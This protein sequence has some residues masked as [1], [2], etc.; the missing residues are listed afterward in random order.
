MAAAREFYGR[1]AR[2]YDYVSRWFPG[3]ATVR[4]RVAAALELSPGDRVVEFGCGTGANFP[5][6]RDA[7]GPD[8]E[9]VG[10]DFTGPSVRRARD[11]ARRRG[12]DNVSVVQADA[13]VPPVAAADGVVATFVMG[14]LDDPAG[15]V[16]DWCDRSSGTVVL[17]DAAPAG[18][19]YGPLVNPPFRAFV[20]VSTPPTTRLRYDR[21]LAAHL[22]ERVSAAHAALGDRASAAAAER[23]CLGLVR[24]TGGRVR[25]M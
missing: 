9:V 1:W 18:P 13:T 4:R 11:R 21:D 22:D 25:D 14:M 17:A 16:A 8:G 5:F 3:I 20:T 10:V 2:L 15:A 12:W 6:L 19:P 23:H 24:L 7:V